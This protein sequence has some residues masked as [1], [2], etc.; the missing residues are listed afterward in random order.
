MLLGE[1]AALLD[2]GLVA[3]D[4]QLG[5]PRIEDIGGR[6]AGGVLA[7]PVEDG[8]G[9]A[10]G[11]QIS[12]V[13]DA[14]DDQRHRD[15]VD[16]QFEEFLGALEFLRKRPAVGDVVEQ[17]DQEFRPVLFV[18]GDHA[19]TGE[20]ALLGAALDDELGAEMAFGRVERRLVRRHD[21]GCGPG[22]EDLVGALADNMVAGEARKTLERAVGEDVAAVLDALGRHAYRNVVEHRFQELL[23]GSQL[24]RKLALFAAIL[25]GGDRTAV[26]QA[27]K[28]DQNRPAVGQLGDEALRAFDAPIEFIDADV[29]HATLPS[30]LQ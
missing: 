6:Q 2:R 21:A 29:E 10:V 13:A 7:P 28:L 18:A 4:D 12:S 20:H 1:Q 22:L 24:P 30:Q 27:E 5:F 15:V 17:R 11:E 8:L 16:H 26:R 14:L 19:V 25:V 3:R 23:G 9:A